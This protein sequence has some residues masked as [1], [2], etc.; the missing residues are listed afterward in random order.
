LLELNSILEFL[1]SGVSND[2][3]YSESYEILDLYDCGESGIYSIDEF[4]S[5]QAVLFFYC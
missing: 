3:F 4:I 5:D 1:S 2:K